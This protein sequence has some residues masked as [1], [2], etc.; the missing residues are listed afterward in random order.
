VKNIN[1]HPLNCAYLLIAYRRWK[2]CVPMSEGQFIT[3]R[4]IFSLI[5]QLDQEVKRHDPRTSAD[6][7]EAVLDLDWAVSADE[8]PI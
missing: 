2:K 6:L 4:L 1:H 7:D 8:N 3:T 5:E